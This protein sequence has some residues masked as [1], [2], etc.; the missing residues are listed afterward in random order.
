LELLDRI[1]V[2]VKALVS[3]GV[4]KNQEDL[5]RLLGYTNKS[6]FSQVL[7]GKVELP[8]DFVDRL[9][10]L[11]DRL[12]K[13]WVAEG[14]GPVLKGF[15]KYKQVKYSNQVDDFNEPKSRYGL[16]VQRV[17]IY[18][19]D[20]EAS[21]VSLFKN[22]NSIHPID[23]ISIPNLPKCDGAVYVKGDGMAPLLKG[24]DIVIYKELPCSLAAVFFGEMYLLYVELEGEA[25]VTLKYLHP[26]RKGDE[27]ISLVSEN[28][29]YQSKEIHFSSIKAMAIVKASIR[30]NSM[31]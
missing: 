5:G 25:F 1:K 27:M 3:F 15:E 2:A 29:I 21:M 22:K 18:R 10:G 13:I 19:F 14:V 16:N 17:P 4:A 23:F 6:S 20:A 8:R 7:N 26:S 31:N 9:C 30:I 11:D 28:G 12:E 24:G